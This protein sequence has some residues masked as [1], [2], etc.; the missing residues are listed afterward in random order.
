M[1]KKT[2]FVAVLLALLALPFAGIALAKVQ[3]YTFTD[4]QIDNQLVTI[5]ASLKTVN[6]G[7]FTHCD[8]HTSDTEQFLGYFQGPTTDVVTEED[9]LNFCVNNFNNRVQ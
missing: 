9:V 4:V 7:D 3:K 6:K 5:Y 1:L 2:L 8:Y